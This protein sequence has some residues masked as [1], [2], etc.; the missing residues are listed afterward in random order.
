MR[1]NK[2]SG[3]LRADGT[4]LIAPAFDKATSFSDGYALVG[5]SGKYGVISTSGRIVVPLRYDFGNALSEKGVFLMMKKNRWFTVAVNSGQPS[6]H[7]LPVDSIP[8]QIS[9]GIVIVH[10]K[11]GKK[12]YTSID[13][14]WI[15]S[16]KFEVAS[17]F[18]NGVAYV[19]NEATKQ[20]VDRVGTE[21]HEPSDGTKYEFRKD[22]D[23]VMIRDSARR[24]R[25]TLSTVRIVPFEGVDGKLG[26]QTT[27]NEMLFTSRFD[28]CRIIATSEDLDNPQLTMGAVLKLIEP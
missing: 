23:A 20:F 27:A 15:L 8:E 9:E 26:L 19:E 16:A 4:I 17:K 3:Y 18:N 1:R 11:D 22:L 10:G 21:I 13:G 28:E 7:A 24:S 5:Q 6:E 2:K 14:K 12:G 25:E